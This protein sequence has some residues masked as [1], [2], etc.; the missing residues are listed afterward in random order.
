MKPDRPLYAALLGWKPA[1]FCALALAIAAFPCRAQKGGSAGGA[2]SNH[3]SMGGGPS[4]GRYPTIYENPTAPSIAQPLPNTPEP[5]KP[6]MFQDENCF[7]WNLSEG[8][9]TA[10]SV[11]RLEVPSKARSEYVKACDANNKNKFD[12]AERHARSAIEKSEN[13]PAAWVMLGMILEEQHKDKDARDAC[14]RA[15]SIDSKYLPAYLCQAEFS[16]R[17]QEWDEVLNLANLALGL[18]SEGDAYAYYYQAAAYFHSNNLVDAKKSALQASE[19]D[20]NH[21]NVSLCF[22]LA[23]IYEAEG[24]KAEAASQLRQI[25]KRHSAK[26]QEDAARQ[27]LAKLDSQPDPK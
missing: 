16:I 18:N 13:Y 19:I 12:D 10:V 6:V 25:L 24:N 9:D 20:V 14:D 8:K 1:A 7:P 3:G 4:V 15:S 21:N 11:T 23:Q 2:G 5:L 26:E 27:E 17:D 22:L